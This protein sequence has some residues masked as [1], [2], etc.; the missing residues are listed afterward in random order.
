MALHN[1]YDRDTLR[2]KLAEEK[3]ERHTVSFYRYAHLTE[4]TTL[5]DTMYAQLQEWSVLGRIYLASEGINAQV[6][7][8]A[9][10]WEA[11][12]AYWESMSAFENMTYRF[13]RED[14]KDSFLK[15]KIKVRE[16]LVADGLD[17]ASFDVTNT[18]NHLDASAFNQAMNQPD[19]VVVDMRNHYE[20]EVGHFEGAL[21]PDVDTFREE[22]P[23][24]LNML[25]GKKENKVLLYC[26]GGIR[27]EKA[28]AFLKHQGFKDVN[29]LRGGII[30]YA[31]QVEEKGLESKFIGKNFVFDDRLGERI[32][33]DVISTCHQCDEKSDHHTNCANNDCHQLF[34]QCPACA[35]KY[36][37]CCSNEC[38]DYNRLP[39]AEKIP[40]RQFFSEVFK[41]RPYR[42]G[43]LNEVSHKRNEIA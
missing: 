10:H 42:K 2:Q 36:E 21:L 17:D 12:A 41:G 7:V 3:F 39:E 37:G 11:F 4:L 22:L 16:K 38:R 33:D 1:I 18:G 20:S 15:L 30:D 27:C 29:Q 13:A 5:R 8:P 28:S 35:K 26:T 43:R 6:N 14:R 24:V 25:E 34:I 9:P 40:F 19:T 23:K 32:T 31:K